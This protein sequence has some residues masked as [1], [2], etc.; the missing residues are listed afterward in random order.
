[1]VEEADILGHTVRT[2]KVTPRKSYKQELFSW[3][4]PGDQKELRTFL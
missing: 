3:E 2:G 1:M 4:V